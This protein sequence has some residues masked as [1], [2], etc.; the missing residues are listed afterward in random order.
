LKKIAKRKRPRTRVDRNNA[1]SVPANCDRADI[2]AARRRYVG[3]ETV[4]RVTLRRRAHALRASFA[5][6]S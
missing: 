3:D 5:H 1:I 6:L 4:S 2:R